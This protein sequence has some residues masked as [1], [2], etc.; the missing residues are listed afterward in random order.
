MLR[1][2]FVL[3]IDKIFIQSLYTF[4]FSGD[5][6]INLQTQRLFMVHTIQFYSFPH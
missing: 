1:Y 3:R 4:L 2:T 6:F 5:I